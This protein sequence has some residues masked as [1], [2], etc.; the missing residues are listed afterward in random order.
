MSRWERTTTTRSTSS[1]LAEPRLNCWISPCPTPNPRHNSPRTNRTQWFSVERSKAFEMWAKI[2]MRFRRRTC[3]WHN[4]SHRLTNVTNA[5]YRPNPVDTPRDG[6]DENAIRPIHWSKTLRVA[7]VAHR[8]I[9][10]PNKSRRGCTEKWNGN[11]CSNVVLRRRTKER[12]F[13][14]QRRWK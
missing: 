10:N 8:L 3:P 4:W 5:K 11:C 6:S 7:F 13:I 12:K 14:D 9:R 1:P 2:L